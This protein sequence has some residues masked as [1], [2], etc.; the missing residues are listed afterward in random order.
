MKVAW[1]RMVFRNYTNFS[2]KSPM[3]TFE[4]V[5]ESSVFAHSAREIMG[6]APKLPCSKPNRI[7][8]CAIPHTKNKSS[9]AS[10]RAIRHEAF[11][12]Y[13]YK[14]NKYLRPINAI[15][16]I[17]RFLAKLLKLEVKNAERLR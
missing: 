4:A 2:L 14:A 9:V 17:N 1:F 6:T 3:A 7:V 5:A 11:L 13:D 10:L 8:I 12:F 15:D 16:Y